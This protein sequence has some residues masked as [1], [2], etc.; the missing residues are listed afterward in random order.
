MVYGTTHNL[1]LKMTCNMTCC[2]R[3]GSRKKK[4]GGGGGGLRHFFRTAASL[5]SRASPK[6]ADERGGGGGLRHILCVNFF[7]RFQ[8]GGGG[9]GRMCPHLNP[10]L[11]C[12][13]AQHLLRQPMNLSAHPRAIPMPT[14]SVPG[15]G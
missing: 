12:I 1:P 8:K 9:T 14:Q 11:C 15:I 2:I 4:R 6:K 13:V 10:P 7:F 3:G 5:E